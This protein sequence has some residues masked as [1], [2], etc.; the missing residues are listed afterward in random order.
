MACIP[1]F[2]PTETLSQGL[3]F[4]NSG[5]TEQSYGITTRLLPKAHVCAQ[6][7]DRFEKIPTY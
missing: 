5:I 3:N 6:P 4:R 7:A 2:L 1:G